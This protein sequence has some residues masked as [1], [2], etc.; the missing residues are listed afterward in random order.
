MSNKALVITNKG[1][2]DTLAFELI[3]ASTKR[4]D[5]QTIGFF[6][7][8]LKYAIAG[9]LRRG[10]PFQVWCGEDL[11][12]ITTEE[13][14]MRD[15]KFERI[16]FNGKPTS[17]TTSMGPR[18]EPWMLVRELY[19]NAIDE[20]GEMAVT[21]DYREFI[22]P[23]RTTII[24]P[25]PD[26]V[27][28]VLAQQEM[29]FCRNREIVFEDG[30][31]RIYEE[32]G[33]A[34]Y[35]VKGIQV[36]RCQ[37][38]TGYGYMLKRTPFEINEERQVSDLF[39]SSNMLLRAILSIEDQKMVRRFVARAK[40][41]GSYENLLMNTGWVDGGTIT[42]PA[43][44][45]VV[46]F[47]SIAKEF[48]TEWNHLVVSENIYRNIN[49]QK[50]WETRKWTPLGSESQNQR[51]RALVNRLKDVSPGALPSGYWQYGKGESRTLS[52]GTEGENIYVN[53]SL[54]ELSDDLLAAGLFR[55]LASESHQLTLVASYFKE[56][57]AQ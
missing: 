10:I 6:G 27:A 42:S 34:G 36:H 31:I 11:L 45:D 2:I 30:R 52:V 55:A 8:G 4:N 26:M 9:L 33:D 40:V 16:F 43:W 18:W 24:F 35:Y 25:D 7:S 32:I 57:L 39:K 14:S 48:V 46:L 54:A 5:E 20:G 15:Q 19:A 22:G 44:D 13:V 21:E 47:R 3:G 1:L 17:L 53:L 56:K 38:Q 41:E 51:L 28:E 23:D 29:L 49:H 37:A 50:K 12:D